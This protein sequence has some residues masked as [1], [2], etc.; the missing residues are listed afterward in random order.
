MRDGPFGVDAIAAEAAAELVV[1]TPLRHSQQAHAD[2]FKRAWI[3]VHG[4]TP[5]AEIELRAVRELRRA[6]EAAVAAIECLRKRLVGPLG[7][8]SRK[9]RSGLRGLGISHRQ[10]GS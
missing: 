2:D 7:R 8:V 10:S 3:A 1:N 5:Q 9:R 6:A 4:V